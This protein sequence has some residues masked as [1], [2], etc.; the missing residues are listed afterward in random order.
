MNRQTI[1]LALL[2]FLILFLEL[3]VIR[4]VSTEIRIFAYLS[5]L[6]LLA[7]FIGSGLGML[8]KRKIPIVVS[9]I[10]LF[11]IAVVLVTKYIVRLPN[12]EFNLFSGITELLTPLSEAHIWLQVST[13]S[14]SGLVIG[15]L[16]TIGLFAVIAL[17]FIPLG[18][19]LGETLNQNRKPILAYSINILASLAGMWA[20]QVFSLL[21]FSPY[22]GL[23]LAIL[24]LL[25]L[26]SDKLELAFGTVFAVAV[27]VLLLPRSAPLPF[28]KPVTFWSPYQKIIL[29]L[30]TDRKPFQASGWILDVNNVYHMALLDLSEQSVA[31]RLPAINKYFPN[32]NDA[33]F[34]NQYSIAYKFN[35]QPTDVLVI[36]GGGGNDVAAAV[37]NGAKTVDVVEI[38]P[39]ILAIGQKY[40]PEKPYSN[41]AVHVFIDDGRAFLQ[42]CNK[43]YDM[44]VMGLVDSHTLSSSLTTLRLDNYLYTQESFASAKNLLKDDGLFVI[45]FAVGRPW[46][47]AR[48]DQTLRAVF[49]QE[50]L[51]FEIQDEGAFGFGG[52]FFITAK[53]ATVIDHALGANNKLAQFVQDHKRVFP[54]K[55]NLLTDDWP[56][57][58]LD[59]P[60]LPLLQLLIAAA[61]IGSLLLI[62]KT[63]LNIKSIDWGFFLLGIA[64][65]LFEF[66]NIS[67]SSLIFGNT[68]TTNLFVITGVLGFIL[69]AN[70]AVFKKLLGIRLS[71]ALLLI[72]L[73]IQFFAPINVFNQIGGLA[74]ILFSILFLCLPHFFSG[75]IFITLFAQAKD[76]SRAFGSNLLGSAIGGLLEV[77]SFLWGVNAM[78]VLCGV[79]YFLAYLKLRK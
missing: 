10:S 45:S 59:Q 64:F 24:T 54:Q 14:L 55:V 58:Y 36:G 27:L 31:E 72:T 11:L 63:I 30:I 22:L 9:S 20:F 51:I 43:K 5:N 67:K 52:T 53:D 62:K 15:L 40:H 7:T 56:Y 3:L 4:L 68:W 78:L 69:L 33:E 75:V 2:S 12:L 37:S 23:F 25:L 42:N 73:A 65:L 26:I 8:I 57:V 16:L 28:E 34:S 1:N 71:F 6:V 77:F 79:F 19:F 38:D 18:Q 61:V 41:P 76:K 21:G 44:I 46:I 17:A 74:K 47:G 49:Q 39:T 70:L 35:S 60:R 32:P 50:P 66:Q 29:S 48:I 13:F